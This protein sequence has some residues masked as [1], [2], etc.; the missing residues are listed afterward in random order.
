MRN[1]AC[2]SKIPYN[3]IFQTCQPSGR[4]CDFFLAAGVAALLCQAS[5][6]QHAHDD[7]CTRMRHHIGQG[8]AI[9]RLGHAHGLEEDVFAQLDHAL[10]QR[11]AAREHHAGRNQVFKT[12]VLHFFLHK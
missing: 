12:R 1:L 10:H 9:L 7:R 5:V 6:F 11:A 4:T 3:K 8:A 2:M